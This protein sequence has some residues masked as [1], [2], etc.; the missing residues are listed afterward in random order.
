MNEVFLV[1]YSVLYNLRFLNLQFNYISWLNRANFL[2]FSE[3]KGD[4]KRFLKNGESWLNLGDWC[5]ENKMCD[6]Y[7]NGDRGDII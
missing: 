6:S 4:T 7:F 1:Q 5:N 3:K 2:S